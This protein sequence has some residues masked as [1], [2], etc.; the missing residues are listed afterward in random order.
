MNREYKNT[1]AEIDLALDQGKALL[2]DLPGLLQQMKQVATDLRLVES[3]QHQHSNDGIR[4]RSSRMVQEYKAI[5]KRFGNLTD[6]IA[7]TAVAGRARVLH[8]AFAEIDHSAYLV[9]EALLEATL[10]ASPN[11]IAAR[12]AQAIEVAIRQGAGPNLK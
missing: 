9:E 6:A 8:T 1:Q 12:Y 4:E 2:K 10:L 3:D 7:K 11:R 5:Q